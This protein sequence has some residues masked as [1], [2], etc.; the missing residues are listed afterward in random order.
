MK[1][2]LDA[3]GTLSAVVVAAFAGLVVVFT[4]PSSFA[5]AIFLYF[6]FIVA[7]AMLIDTDQL[8]NATTFVSAMAA[9]FVA[10][11]TPVVVF[12]VA[13]APSLVDGME[14]YDAGWQSSGDID[15]FKPDVLAFVL[16]V[17]FFCWILSGFFLFVATKAAPSLN[18]LIAGIWHFGPDGL[19]RLRLILVGVTALVGALAAF[20]AGLQ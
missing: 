1:K 4:L 3:S 7:M 6:F 9:S 5:L 19:K 20:V 13:M 12:Y 16:V 17:H 2:L 8:P 14:P 18:R 10:V 15:P 11:T